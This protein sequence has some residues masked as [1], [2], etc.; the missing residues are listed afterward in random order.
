[1]EDHFV[2]SNGPEAGILASR[3]LWS[4]VYPLK[5]NREREEKVGGSVTLHLKGEGK[6]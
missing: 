5:P 6:S 3:L 2:Q 4:E 1:M